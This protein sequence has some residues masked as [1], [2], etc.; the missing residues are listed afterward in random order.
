MIIRTGGALILAATILMGCEASG[1]AEGDVNA[2]DVI[3][4][5][6][7]ANVV[8]ASGDADAAVEFFRNSLTESPERV[9]FQRGYAVSLS[10]AGRHEEATIA[11]ER[12]DEQGDLQPGDR[13]RYAESLIRLNEWNRAE[14]QLSLLGQANDNYRWNLLNA[15]IADNGQNWDIADRFYA[16]ARG[17]TSAPASVLNNWG[18]SK[19]S[20]GDLDGAIRNFSEA[21]RFDATL[22]EAKNNLALARGLQGNYS[23]PVVPLTEI[24]RAQIY[25]NLAV[26]ALRQGEDDIARGLLELAVETH[27]QFFPAA[28]DKLAGLDTQVDR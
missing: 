19:M 22:F 17:L 24:E 26:V 23:I 2:V 9:D 4:S 28:A 1:P 13:L 27:P 3:D 8:L 7:L 16:S 10:R 14:A 20:R 12:L 11:F 18:I 6:N 25:H 5:T 21:V 15:L